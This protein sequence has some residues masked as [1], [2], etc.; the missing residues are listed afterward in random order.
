MTEEQF[1]AIHKRLD[2]MEAFVKDEQF[3]ALNRRFDEMND[4]LSTLIDLQKSILEMMQ[5]MGT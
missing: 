3:E 5:K 4:K 1:E 2:S